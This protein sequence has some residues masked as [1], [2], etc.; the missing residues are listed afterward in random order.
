M[1]REAGKHGFEALVVWA[2]RWRDSEPGL[3]DVEL[4]LMPRQQAVR[5]GEGVAVMVDGDGLFEM[6]RL[7]NERGL[8]LVAQVHSH[9]T[10]AYHSDTDDQFSTITARGGLSL[11]VPDF[12]RDPFSL[13]SCAVY[14]LEAGGEWSEVSA[15]AAEA[16]IRITEDN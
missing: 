13:H 6:N 9:P 4:V 7:L 15:T 3:F 16:L 12:A 8:R 2:G 10:E 11:V 14:R 5:T 1:L